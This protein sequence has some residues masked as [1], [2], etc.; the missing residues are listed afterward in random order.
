MNEIDILGGGPAGL[1]SAFYAKK[2][3]I[4]FRLYESQKK[5]GGNCKTLIFDECNFDTGA[6]RLHDKDKIAIK[7]I[8]ELIKDD[9]LLVDAPSKILWKN[10][11][12]NFPLE[13]M[14]IVKS[15][16]KKDI[17]KITMENLAIL[18]SKSTVEDNFQQF[19]YKKYGKTLSNYFLNNYTEKLWGV[20]TQNLHPKVSGN[21]LNNLNILSMFRGLIT[22][23][24]TKHYEGGFWYPRKGYGQIF[25][26]IYS[27]LK[28]SISCNSKIDKIYHDNNSIENISFSNGKNIKVQKVISTL[29]I[30]FLINNLEP[31]A[32]KEIIELASSFKFRNLRLGVFTLNTERFTKNASIYFPQKNLPFTRIYEPKNRSPKMAPA[33]KTCI[34]VEVPY[35]P[36]D[37]YDLLPD[38]EFLFDIK[39][40]LIKYE[41][42]EKSIIN[43]SKSIRMLNAYPVLTIK[44]QF[45]LERI[46]QFLA[47]FTN[48]INIGR[49]AQFEYLHTHQLFRSAYEKISSIST[50]KK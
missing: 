28:D 8:K 6:H 5:I 43:K 14:N 39:N 23:K 15:L 32:P 42:I 18:L 27:N 2:K 35:S 12:I 50:N 47:A 17:I 37:V 19:A 3:N 46:N 11:M 48:L 9:L 34:V 10:K 22:K 24:K 16:S 49:N 20:S 1:A 44:S 33:N 45:H 38:D 4:S 36:N 40:S 21:R 31:K 25:D 26:V 30:D 29:P 13:P 41:L 7:T